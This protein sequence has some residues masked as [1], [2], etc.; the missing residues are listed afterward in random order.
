[1]VYPDKLQAIVVPIMNQVD[2]DRIYNRSDIE[3][4]AFC[5]GDREGN[6]GSCL[7]DSGG[8]LVI[9]GRLA[10]IMSWNFGDFNTTRKPDVFVNLAYPLHRNWIISTINHFESIRG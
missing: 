3:Q 4:K 9:D 10:G 5:T 7:G 1:M 6:K 2:C 8:P